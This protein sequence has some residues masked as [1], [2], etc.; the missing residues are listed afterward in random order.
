[1]I[2]KQKI[3]TL[4]LGTGLSVLALL[5]LLTIIV[6]ALP[7]FNAPARVQ[8]M[9]MQ[10]AAEH[11]NTMIGIIV[12][13]SVQ[14]KS[15][16]E[17]V[18]K[19]NGAVTE[20]LSIINAF[21]ATL[22]ANTVKELAAAN[23]VKWVSLDAPIVQT[24]CTLPCIDTSNLKSIYPQ[25]IKATKLWNANGNLQGQGIAVA[26]VDSGINANH[27]DLLNADG[28]S[29]VIASVKMNSA[30]T[31]TDD[32]MGHGTFVAGIIG[33][34][35][36]ASNGAYIG[37]APQ[38]NLVNVKIS[39]DQ[40]N[41]TA[42]NL[43]KGLQWIYNNRKQYNIRAVSLS[44]NVTVDESYKTSPV[45]A[46][47]EV[48]WFNQV[49]VVV[50]SGN[51][52]HK[53]L[54]PPA[55]DPFVITVGAS[56]DNGTITS[57]DDYQTNY[58]GWGKT[59]DGISKPDL[60]A[61][62]NNIISLLSNSQSAF[63]IAHPDHL[64]TG[65]SGSNQ[66]FRLSGTSMAAPMVAGATAL[67]LQSSPTLTPDQVKFRMVKTANFI[68]G[69][70]IE[71]DAFNAVMSNQTKSLNTGTAINNML[72]ASNQNLGWTSLNWDSLNWDSLNWDSL[73]WDSLNWDSLNWNSLN[74][75]SVYW[76][77]DNLSLTRPSPNTTSLGKSK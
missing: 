52:G 13:K 66:Y 36:K 20:D 62:G 53:A 34:N 72:K 10:M 46:A 54:Y 25:T 4:K 9:L 44:L 67:V 51:Q 37:L 57:L 15:V 2:T 1:M 48:L 24:A 50:A 38:V 70:S 77:E 17:L 19:L 45:D 59:I 39:D 26:V 12:Q 31:T 49:V 3:M 18:A 75:D 68:T 29:R 63:A 41:A 42:T 43:I 61:P 32:Y 58:S 71:L 6:S 21:A 7:S 69:G 73:N 40:G 30:A 56:A 5:A 55:N 22:P 28:T 65:F 47:V 14:D 60:V 8:P 23:G 27:P 76:G 16:E 74:W 33:G 35:G 11:P 64:V